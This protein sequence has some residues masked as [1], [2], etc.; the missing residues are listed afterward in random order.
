MPPEAVDIKK[1]MSEIL[2][3]REA[4][5]FNDVNLIY[6]HQL[7][8]EFDVTFH[9]IPPPLDVLKINVHGSPSSIPLP[10]GNN[11][12]IWAILRGANGQW[13]LQTHYHWCNPSSFQDKKSTFGHLQWHLAFKEGYRQVIIETDNY[14]AFNQKL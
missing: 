12:G 5:I 11:T 2:Y 14:E 13:S 7:S 4:L 10:N 3:L 9:W 1:V 6:M 8:Q